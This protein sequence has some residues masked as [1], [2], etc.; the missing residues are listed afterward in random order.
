MWNSDS[1]PSPQERKPREGIEAP[2][3][4]L[5]E[6]K[7]ARIMSVAREPIGHEGNYRLQLPCLLCDARR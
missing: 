3:H 2:A 1:L 6:R 5:C 4:Y 7:C